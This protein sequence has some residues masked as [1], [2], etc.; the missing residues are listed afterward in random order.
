MRK[1]VELSGCHIENDVG[2]KRER[3][4]E[5]KK[6]KRKKKCAI[7]KQAERETERERDVPWSKQQYSS[8][9]Q[10]LGAIK[11]LE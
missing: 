6:R 4:R 7:K 9:L 8:S 1:I 11:E 5:R 10:K 2:C 3:E